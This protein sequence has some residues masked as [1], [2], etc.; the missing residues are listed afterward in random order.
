MKSKITIALV[1]IFSVLC[2]SQT[3]KDNRQFEKNDKIIYLD[4]MRIKSSIEDHSFYRIIKDYQ[5]DKDSYLVYEF[6]KSGGLLIESRI[7]DKNSTGKDGEIIYF[8]ENGNKKAISNYKKGRP[9][10]KDEQWYE[11]GNKKLEGK[12]IANEEKLTSQH[13]IDQFWDES[14]VQKV[15]DG[16]GFF[17]SQEKK[18]SSKGE[19]KNGVKEGVWSGTFEK[20]K[21]SYTETYKSGIL[22]SG[23]CMDD[24]SKTYKYKV[25]QVMPKPKNGITDFYK[26]I[27]KNYKSPD[28][29]GL[30]GK[31]YIQFVVDVDGKI[32]EPKVLRDLGYGTGEEAIRVVTAYDGFEPGEYRG[33]KV[34]CVYSLPITIKSNN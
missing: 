27:G 19:I 10:G 9:N 32:I 3:D 2:H 22:I 28:V 4:S 7:T 23:V 17:E 1:L 16:N 33:R 12:Y 21:F 34:R 11:N 14:G 20:G 15:I 8:Y 5:L 18:E 13:E 24:K 29:K 31:V 30:S 25:A 26:F 6:N